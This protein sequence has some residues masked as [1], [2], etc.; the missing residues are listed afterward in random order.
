MKKGAVVAVNPSM[1]DKCQK[2]DVALEDLPC[3]ACGTLPDMDIVLSPFFLLGQPIEL[4]HDAHIIRQQYFKRQS[5]LHPDK[6]QDFSQKEKAIHWSRMVNKA[7][8][9]LQSPLKCAKA[10]LFIKEIPDNIT[11]NDTALLVVQMAYIEEMALI[12]NNSDKERY[13]KKVQ[14]VFQQGCEQFMQAWESHDMKAL[15][16]QY[17]MLAFLDKLPSKCQIQ[18]GNI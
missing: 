12:A 8:Q 9:T 15:E 7:Y 14:D 3:S 18:S 10:M 6:W 4:I 13:L 16:K 1:S 2:C 17:A 11:L 5:V